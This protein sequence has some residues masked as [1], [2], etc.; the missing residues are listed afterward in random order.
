[1]SGV[2]SHVDCS[3]YTV[4]LLTPDPTEYHAALSVGCGYSHVSSP[5]FFSL[6][7]CLQLLFKGIFKIQGFPEA[8]DCPQNGRICK[9]AS[10]I[11]CLHARRSRQVLECDAEVLMVGVPGLALPD[12]ALAT[13]RLPSV[14]DMVDASIANS[15]L[16]RRVARPHSPEAAS[17]AEPGVGIPPHGKLLSCLC[18]IA[19][20]IR[21][22]RTGLRHGLHNSSQLTAGLVASN[23][24]MAAWHACK[25]PKVAGNC[26]LQ[27]TGPSRFTCREL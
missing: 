23:F 5:S 11:H 24:P 4:W 19:L 2:A 1:M 10:L 7:S 15:H 17:K 22:P 21:A 12:S 6:F 25:V 14:P 27:C 26:L 8:K 3:K 13:A 18:H 9:G 20:Q 16:A